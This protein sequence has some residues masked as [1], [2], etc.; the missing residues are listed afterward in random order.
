MVAAK[1][2]RTYNTWLLTKVGDEVEYDEFVKN[3]NNEG[4]A[5]KLLLSKI[6]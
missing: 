2:S 1:L 3:M 5:E 4:A 6:M